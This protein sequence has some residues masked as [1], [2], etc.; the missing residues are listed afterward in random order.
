MSKTSTVNLTLSVLGDGVNESDFFTIFS[1]AASPGTR[2]SLALTTGDNNIQATQ[3]GS[4]PV[5]AILQPPSGST[6][7]KL[8]KGVG[9][10]SGIPVD[11]AS[12]IVLGFSTAASKYVL[13]LSGPE[14][15][16]VWYL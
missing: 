4:F 2:T 16:S 12:P 3:V 7:T 13:N 11:P 14:T 9:G 10:D 15:V 1:S 6:V 8:L 5:L